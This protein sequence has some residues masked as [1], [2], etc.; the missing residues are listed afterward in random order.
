[1]PFFWCF[2]GKKYPLQHVLE[3]I[4]EAEREGHGGKVLLEC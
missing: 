3:A 1:M 4:K 2:P